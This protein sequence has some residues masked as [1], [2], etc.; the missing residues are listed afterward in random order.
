MHHDVVLVAMPWMSLHYPSIQLGILKPVL[1]NAGINISTKTL[2]VAWADALMSETRNDP[3]P[4]GLSD[5]ED[6]AGWSSTHGLGEWVFAMTDD[7][8]Q[9]TLSDQRYLE[10][11]SADGVPATLLRKAQPSRELAS[12]FIDKVASQ[13]L[14]HHPRVVGLSMVFSQTAPSVRL[15]RRLKELDPNLAIVCGGA[16]CEGRMGEAMIRLFPWIDVVVRGEAEYSAPQVFRALLANEQ[17]PPLN[18]I[19]VRTN[20][21]LTSYAE[22][23]GSAVKMSDVPTPDYSD[24]FEDVQATSIAK[25]V[26]A[27]IALPFEASRGCWWGAKSH[28]TFCG[29]NDNTMVFAVNGAVDGR[30]GPKS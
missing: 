22:P 3:E 19:S 20:G 13:I 17:V 12:G 14:S 11:L 18:G 10:R 23:A 8:A 15:A 24:F 4:I 27:G 16:N 28:C 1:S 21:E 25:R 26:F 6:I 30:T 9:R 5:Y 29:L 2:S 7:L